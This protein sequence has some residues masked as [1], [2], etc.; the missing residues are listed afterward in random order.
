MSPP[1]KVKN[2][3]IFKWR[4]ILKLFNLEKSLKLCVEKGNFFNNLALYQMVDEFWCLCD[5]HMDLEEDSESVTKCPWKS[6]RTRLIQL[7]VVELSTVGTTLLHS[8]LF[9]NISPHIKPEDKKDFE[10]TTGEL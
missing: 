7:C 9:T 1:H 4:D 5:N 6:K 2:T 3:D 10:N 8:R